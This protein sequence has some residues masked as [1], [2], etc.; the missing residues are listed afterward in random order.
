MSQRELR[1][2][3]IPT[4]RQLLLIVGWLA[5]FAGGVTTPAFSQTGPYTIWS[6]TTLPSIADTG[7]DNPVELGVKFRSDADGVVTGVRFYKGAGNTGTHI[8]QALD[9]R[10]RA[11]RQR[12]LHR[13]NRVRMAAGGFSCAHPGGCQHHLRRLV[14][15]GCGPLQLRREL[16]CDKR[17]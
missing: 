2:L 4:T 12:H 17:R 3:R 13:R 5:L 9:R 1:P 8:G 10:R 14:P 7:A 16:L 15:H 11:A 6:A